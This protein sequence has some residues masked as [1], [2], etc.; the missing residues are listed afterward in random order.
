M[1]DDKKDMEQPEAEREIVNEPQESPEQKGKKNNPANLPVPE[2]LPVLPLHGFVFFPGMGFPMQISHPS[3]QQLVDE[4]IIKDRLVAVVTHRRLEEEEDETARPS[5]ALPEIPAT[6]KG[7][8]LYSMGVVGYMHKLIKSDD[9]VYQ[10]LISAVKKLRIVE[11][12][13]HTPYLQARVEV[14]PMEES[15]DQESEA[16][17]LNIRNQFK[18]MADLGGVP[19]ELGM[20]VAALT[21]PFYIAYLVVSQVGLS[22][23]EEE[24][25]LEIEDLKALLN[26][27]GHELNKKLETLEMSHKIQKGI[28]QDMDKKQREFFLREQ[29]KAIRKELGEDDENIDLKDLRERLEASD[30]PEEPKKTAEKELDRL[31]RISPSSPEYTVSRTYLDWLIDL[32]WQTCT[33]DNLDLKRAQEVLDAD[34]YGL[35]DIKKRII[36]FLAVRKLKHDMHGPILCFAGPPGVGKTSLGQSIARSMGRK[37]VRISLGGV[38]DEAEIRGHRRTYIGALPGRI[39][40]SLRKAGS[41]NPLFMLDEIDK[42]GMDFRGDPSSALLEVLD[43]EQNFSFSDHYLEI[44]FDLSRV[45]FITTAN[46]LDNI[47]GPL[48]DRMEVIELSGYTE[49]EKMHIARRHLVPKQLEAHAISEDDL[50]LSDQ[51]LAGIIRSY[52]REAGVRN[53]ERKIGGV[54]R[55]VARKIVEGHSGLI[56]VGPDDL[57]EYLGPPQFFSESKARTWGPGLATGLAWTPVGGDLLFIETA[58]MKG[59]GNLSLTGKL[60]EVMKESANAALTYIRS[61]TDKLGLDEKIFADNDLHV[62][63]PEGAIPKDG[64]SAGVAMVVSLASQLMGRPVRREVAMTGEITLRGDVLP[65]GG[66]KEK[67]LAAVRADISEVILPKLNEKD[68]T[69]LPESA[70]K[71][72]KFH[73]VHDINEALE[74]AL[75]P[76]D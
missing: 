28:K 50:R 61:H 30:L 74:K 32:P 65:V 19:K 14:V 60:G 38:R 70:R 58:R 9:G 69:E 44:P 73:L 42:L 43:P 54:C 36:E 27:V 66:I 52:T 20:T 53:L 22:M 3:S 55:G 10:V 31:N 21:N 26:R 13:Q 76:D 6:P 39:I 59:K 57:A 1:T 5:E 71:K 16:M 48:R 75:E 12:T 47:P 67:V 40:Q 15:M 29:L 18:K 41:C 56:E 4:T 7:E 72:V 35:D 2:E 46:L 45:M 63:V 51:A 25:V 8:N 17:L 33:E 11:Y 62:H 23:E 49:E 37:F 24:A 34:H 68:L 64:P